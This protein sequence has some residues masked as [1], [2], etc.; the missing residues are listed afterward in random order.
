MFYRN[1]EIICKRWCPS[2]YLVLHRN[3]QALV[4]LFIL[5]QINQNVSWGWSLV[6]K[7]MYSKMRTSSS[8][9][10]SLN[11]ETRTR[12]N[13]AFLVKLNPHPRYVLPITLSLC[14]KKVFSPY[15]TW[16]VVDC[17]IVSSFASVN[18]DRISFGDA[19][20][21]AVLSYLLR[22]VVLVPYSSLKSS[23]SVWL[24]TTDI[25]RLKFSS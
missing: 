14:W 15:K 2:F 23:T 1:V 25:S 4:K 7:M 16:A 10:K 24:D 20:S 12:W 19:S 9:E 11:E 22:I 18:K 8:Y 3:K 21:L 17:D 13:I 6:N 5:F